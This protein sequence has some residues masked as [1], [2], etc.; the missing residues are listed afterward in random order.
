MFIKAEEFFFMCTLYYLNY[1]FLITWIVTHWDLF[2][3]F[4]F[5]V[6][7]YILSYFYY[8]LFFLCVSGDFVI[9]LQ[10]AVL[11]LKWSKHLRFEFSYY[12][13]WKYWAYTLT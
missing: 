7:L 5:I 11:A 4:L 12:C 6:Y 2:C 8:Y 3:I 9:G 10:A 13:C 1:E